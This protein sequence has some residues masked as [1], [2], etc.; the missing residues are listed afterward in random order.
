MKVSDLTAV[1]LTLNEEAYIADCLDSLKWCDKVTVLDSLSADRTVEIARQ[2]GAEVTLRPLTDFGDQRNAA[3]ELTDSDWVLFVDAD[4]R[5][6]PELAHEVKLAIQE[7]EVDGWWIPT[8]NYFFGRLLSHGGFY[9]D[10]HLRLSR[11]GKLHYD[12]EEKVHERPVLEG[13]AG[14]LEN[15]LIHLCY[16]DIHEMVTAKNRYSALLAR[17]HCEKG[18][19]PTYHLITAPIL[20]LFEQFVVLKGFKDGFL[21]LFISLV[22]SYYAFDEYRRARMLWKSSSGSR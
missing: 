5:V 20:T 10:Y 9:P 15:P 12:F 6:S 2:Y 21:G 19:K 7:P 16:R 14:Y 11:K 3:L 18:L 8:K 4:E 17:I 13:N 1:V 22:W